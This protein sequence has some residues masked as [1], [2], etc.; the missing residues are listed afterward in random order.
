L[1]HTFQGACGSNDYCDDTPP[2]ANPSFNTCL[3]SSANTCHQDVPDLVD[4]YENYMDYSDGKCQNMFT[5]EQVGLMWSHLASQR[6]MLTTN[7]NL[8]NTGVISPLT[9]CGPKAQFYAVNTNICNG[10]SITFKDIS[11]QNTSSL[12]YQW[13][14]ENG[15]PATSTSKNPVVTYNDPSHNKV[16]LIVSNAQGSDTA[17]VSNYIHVLGSWVEKETSISE[18]FETAN[19]PSGWH[20]DGNT[21]SNWERTNS[22]AYSGK[23]SLMIKNGF[24]KANASYKLITKQYDASGS[25]PILNFKYSFCQRN[26]SGTNQSNDQLTF[27]ISLDCG[28]TWLSKWTN[29]GNKLNTLNNTPSYIYDYFPPDQSSWKSISIDLSAVDAISRRNILF[30]WEFVSDAGNNMFL[31]DINLSQ[32][33]STN[34]L[35]TPKNVVFQNPT[36]N[37]IELHSQLFTQS[38]CTISIFDISGRLVFIEEKTNRENFLLLNTVL[39]NGNYIMKIDTPFFNQSYKLIVH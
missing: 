27:K 19:L 38:Q 36:S 25:S 11:Y 22:G 10:N 6:S 30:A 35:N 8:I 18:S 15:T 20:L 13:Y 33:A 5:K 12:S 39:N 17:I 29:S 24:G 2:V 23:Y 26:T 4:Q 28:K 37:Q 1:F 31:D 14:F 9:N 7:E 3:P 34:N 16:T 21:I 32:I